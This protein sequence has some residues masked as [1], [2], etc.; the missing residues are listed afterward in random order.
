[1]EHPLEGTQD[2][3]KNGAVHPLPDDS[4]PVH[5][6]DPVNNTPITPQE[7]ETPDFIPTKVVIDPYTGKKQWLGG[8]RHKL[9]HNEFHNA[10]TQ[11]NRAIKKITCER[12]DRDAQTYEYKNVTFQTSQE[13][14]TQMTKPGHYVSTRDDVIITPG[15]YTLADTIAKRRNNAAIVIQKYFRRYLAKIITAQLKEDRE[16]YENWLEEEK[17]RIEEERRKRR[18][19]NLEG[20]L[21]PRS[22]KDFD[23]VWAALTSWRNEQVALIRANS[24]TLAE[25]K[26][27][28]ATLEEQVAQLVA[29]IGRHKI[30][31]NQETKDLKIAKF[32]NSCAAPRK[33]KAKDGKWISMVN[34]TGEPGQFEM[35]TGYTLRAKELRDLYNALKMEG[36]NREER[37]DMLLTLKNIVAGVPDCKLTKELI[38]LAEREAEM[39]VRGVNSSLLNGLR[40]RI[41][42][43]YLQF[44][45][46]PKFNPE[47]AR[48][49]TVPQDAEALRSKVV[50]M[51]SSSNYLSHWPL[52]IWPYAAPPNFELTAAHRGKVNPNPHP[53]IIDIKQVMKELKKKYPDSDLVYVMAEG[54]IRHLVLNIWSMKSALSHT[55]E[56]LTLCKWKKSESWS[57]WNCFLITKREEEAHASFAS[58]EDGY[59]PIMFQKVHRKHLQARQYFSRVK[60]MSRFLRERSLGDGLCQEV[61]GVSLI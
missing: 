12:N 32:L 21:N 41:L 50:K 20:R 5:Y 37:I 55:Q 48:H 23:L 13:A 14:S 33:W 11:T 27:A 8:W 24:E 7:N 29:A 10:E 40:A 60:G 47:A 53:D 1:M 35:E 26:A 54:D 25:Q 18:Q 15:E 59:G 42:H 43:L 61:T 19:K 28:L 34:W 30:R 49:L 52:A 31:A 58:P 56:D 6:E 36:L 2:W 3:D 44:C 57:P 45:R 4:S 16:A 22:K 17:E 46:D 9:N 39:L 51:G 38:G